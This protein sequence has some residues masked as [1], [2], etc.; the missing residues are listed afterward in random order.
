MFDQCLSLS[1]ELVACWALH[2]RC[3]ARFCHPKTVAT[4]SA[5]WNR[6][7][8]GFSFF[9]SAHPIFG[10]GE[11]AEISRRWVAAPCLLPPAQHLLRQ[12]SPDLRVSPGCSRY[13]NLNGSED[14]A[15][16]DTDKQHVLLS[17]TSAS[18]FSFAFA[19]S[20]QMASLNLLFNI[21]TTFPFG[22]NK[23]AS[24]LFSKC[25]LPS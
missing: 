16:P 7:K 17:E 10:T 23:E 22:K 21:T 4:I 11:A 6:P 20:L 3:K 19:N 24:T 18:T 14:A 5:A 25:R 1:G 13:Q 12:A 2:R 8:T 15:D 9:A